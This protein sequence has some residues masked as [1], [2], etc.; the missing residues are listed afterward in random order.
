V[1]AEHARDPGRGAAGA[2]PAD[3]YRHTQF[4][5]M[6]AAVTV[7]GLGAAVLLTLKLSR[8]TMEAAP[9]A[10]VAMYAIIAATFLLFVT[11]TV[12][13]DAREVRVRFGIG[14]FRKT[15][16]LADVRRCEVI[17][18]RVWWGWGLHWTP[19]GWLY[20]VAGRE[21]VRLELVREKAVMIGSDEALA[22]KQA[23]DARRGAGPQATGR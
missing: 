19:S 5:T 17:R 18:T 22:L 6:I 23:I 13:V 1:A 3:A 11:L 9:W 16:A 12:E 10:V 7:L 8:A 15:I 21:A 20:N 4:G 14:V 2:P